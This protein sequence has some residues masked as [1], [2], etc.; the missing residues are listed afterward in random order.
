[1]GE[2]YAFQQTGIYQTAAE[3]AKAPYDIMP[4]GTDKTKFAGDAIFLDSDRN[5]TID[6]R[7]RIYMGNIYPRWTGGI[8][9]DVTY[10]GFNLMIRFDYMTGQTIYNYMRATTTAQLAGDLG[11]SSYAGQSWMKEGDKTDV[12]KLYYGDWQYNIGRGTSPYYEKGNYLALREVT[13]SYDLP[14]TLSN[15]IGIKGARFNVS[16]QN[17]HYFTKYKGINPENGGTDNG[18]YPIPRNILFGATISL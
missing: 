9:T 12:P 16:G 5:D 8:S 10:K 3:A 18:S 14:A 17:L 15:R 1:M 4:E 2:L 11:L 7:D 13:L 6:L